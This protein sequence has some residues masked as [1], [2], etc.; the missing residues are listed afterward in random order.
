[1]QKKYN[2]HHLFFHSFQKQF[3]S[4]GLVAKNLSLSIS[5]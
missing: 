1:M 3:C 5:L 4:S 2:V